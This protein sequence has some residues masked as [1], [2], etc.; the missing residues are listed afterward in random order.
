MPLY[1]NSLIVHE[2]SRSFWENRTFFFLPF[3]LT[4]LPPS[5]ELNPLTHLMKISKIM[6][7]V[8][9]AQCIVRHGFFIGGNEEGGR[10]LIFVS[11]CHG[12]PPYLSLKAFFFNGIF[13]CFSFPP[14]PSSIKKS[15]IVRRKRLTPSWDLVM[16]NFAN[17]LDCRGPYQN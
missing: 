13:S 1:I 15:H 9:D 4:L 11:V 10:E 6:Y 14:Y 17:D 8:G 5:L 3:L 7:A 12:F 2:N 16:S